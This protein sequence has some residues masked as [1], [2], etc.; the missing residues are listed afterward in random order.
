MSGN[1]IFESIMKNFEKKCLN[2]KLKNSQ[3]NEVFLIKKFKPKKL[4]QKQTTIHNND[5]KK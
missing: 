1:T 5:I 2:S 3:F 4:F